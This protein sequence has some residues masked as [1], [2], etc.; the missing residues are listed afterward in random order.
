[1]YAL[2]LFM[3]MHNHCD[4]R[5]RQTFLE[6]FYRDTVNT[7]FIFSQWGMI[8]D[9]YSSGDTC[10]KKEKRNSWFLYPILF[11]GT[12]HSKIIK[13]NKKKNDLP[14]GH[15]RYRW[16]CFFIGTHLEKCSITSLAHQWILCSE[17]V[18]SE[19]E[20]KQLKKH[21]NNESINVLCSKNL[22]NCKK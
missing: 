11:K 12:V 14:S 16:V 1:M 13:K 19:W 15:L 4:K 21:H 7:R 17:W 9:L 2:L 18:P 3:N 10:A 5:E 8:G 20:S 22:C 6:M